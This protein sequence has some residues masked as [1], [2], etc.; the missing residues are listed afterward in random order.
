MLAADVA[1]R[2]NLS[3]DTLQV[4][5]KPLDEQVLNLSEPLFK[6]QI[7]PTRVRNLGDVEWDVTII[8]E[9]G[10]RKITI[11]A[12]AQCLGESGRAH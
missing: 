8:S 4:D 3:P 12:S 1:Q 11:D 5:F 2:L 9:S 7:E 10:N 6:F